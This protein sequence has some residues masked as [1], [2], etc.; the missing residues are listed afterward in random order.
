MNTFLAF[1]SFTSMATAIIMPII[2]FA[3]WVIKKA[4]EN[5]TRMD[6]EEKELTDKMTDMEKMIHEQ[7]KTNKII[8]IAACII[9]YLLITKSF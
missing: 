4:K 2:L 1:L 6:L 7:K 3:K 9:A 5:Q 8:F